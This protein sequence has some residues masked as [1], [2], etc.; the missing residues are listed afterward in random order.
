MKSNFGDEKLVE[1]ILAGNEELF[2]EIVKRY[3]NKLFYYILRYCKNSEDA[4]D[5]LQN[6]LFKVYK[7]LRSFNTKRKFS[8]WIYRIA[9]N[10][11]VNFI[12]FNFGKIHISIDNNEYL[13][14]TLGTHDN[15]LEKIDHK[16]SIEK[17]K[18]IIE[19]LP[20]QYKDVIIL[21]F[22]EEKSYEEI[23]DIIRKPVSTVGT[24][25]NRAKA[26]IKS[27]VN[28]NSID[29]PVKKIFNTLASAKNEIKHDLYEEN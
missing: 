7:N 17:L 18:K 9:H 5:L 19:T 20:L 8:S 29:T 16:T 28:K 6:V 14:N 12:R 26:K 11:A 13:Q 3:Q 27:I 23:S 1:K 21:R 2:S 4:Q 24:L 25:I 15:T 22:F 10:E